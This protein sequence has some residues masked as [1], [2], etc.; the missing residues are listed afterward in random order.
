MISTF[1]PGLSA[2]DLQSVASRIN[3]QTASAAEIRAL[4]TAGALPVGLAGFA[5]EFILG[6]A[7]LLAGQVRPET[8]T[9]PPPAI[10]ADARN[11]HGALFLFNGGL[12]KPP[13]L[14]DASELIRIF[15]GKTPGQMNQ[16]RDAYAQ[17]FGRDL[18]FDV[19]MAAASVQGNLPAQVAGLPAKMTQA[20]DLMMGTIAGA[21]PEGREVARAVWHSNMSKSTVPLRH[22]YSERNYFERVLVDSKDVFPAIASDILESRYEMCMETFEWAPASFS[23]PGGTT[24]DPTWVVVNALEQKMAQLRASQRPGYQ[25]PKP[26]IPWKFHLA[27]DGAAENALVGGTTAVEKCANFLRQLEAIN[28]DPSLVEVHVYAHER[29]ATGALHSKLTVTDGYRLNQHGTNPQPQQTLNSSWHDSGVLLRGEAGI[30]ARHNFDDTLTNS[31]EVT[32]FSWPDTSK[33]PVVT[34]ARARPINH[35]PAVLHPDLNQDPLLRGASLPVLFISQ[36]AHG[37][38][39]G[40]PATDS[41]LATAVK[42]GIDAARSDLVYETPNLNNDAVL[43]KIVDAVMRRRVPFRQILSLGFNTVAERQNVAGVNLG[44]GSNED[45]VPAL[46]RR[47]TDVAARALLQIR[48]NGRTSGRPPTFAQEVGASHAKPMVVN[49]QLSYPM[50]ANGDNASMMLIRETGM[51]IDSAAVARQFLGTLLDT[52]FN[53]S[54]DVFAWARGILDGSVP[55]PNG[56]PALVGDVRAYA[57]TLVALAPRT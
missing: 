3:W 42:A 27:I 7:R 38:E 23:R 32:S 31:R 44:G 18:D 57:Q 24:N 54:M 16:L 39:D 11:V 43:D 22:L 30:A 52:D 40:I 19:R 1:V 12:P 46:Y 8:T 35:H 10:V 9:P 2:K 56:L 15:T 53:A 36:R 21:S 55:V 45:I 4:R 20:I 47:I 50:S 13:V 26:E 48:W 5:D 37:I 28:L 51:V 34:L 49:R 25:G 6:A 17:Q 29:T 41:P 14:N 33:P